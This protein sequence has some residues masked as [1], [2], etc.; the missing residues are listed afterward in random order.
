MN[1]AELYQY[2]M[3]KACLCLDKARDMKKKN[4]E[5]LSKFYYNAYLGFKQKAYKVEV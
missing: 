2:Y 5:N 1:G 3:N 4:D